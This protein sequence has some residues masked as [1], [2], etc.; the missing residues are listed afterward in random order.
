MDGGR[1]HATHDRRGHELLEVVEAIV[2]AMVAIATA[3]SGYQAAR[4]GGAQ[5][6]LYGKSS[7][8]RI[9]AQ[10]PLLKGGQQHIHDTS[11]ATEWLEASFRGEKD[12]ANF[13][14][15][16]VRPEARPAFEA[17]KSSDPVHNPQAPEG[18]SMMP[19]YRNDALEESTKLDN[20]ASELFEQGTNARP[21]VR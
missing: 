19:Q 12:L 3:W 20:E 6:E 8:L 9:A 16:R 11:L 18:P 21:E 4:W 13:L 1:N 10:G 17:W 15:R 14:E 2:L 7:K 5:T